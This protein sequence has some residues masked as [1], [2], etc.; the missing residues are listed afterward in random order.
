MDAP[1]QEEVRRVARMLRGE[2]ERSIAQKER[3]GWKSEAEVTLTIKGKW[4]HRTYAKLFG[5]S[6]PL[7]RIVA[8]AREP[9]KIIVM[10][11]AEKLLEAAINL[12]GMIEP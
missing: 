12:E 7:G 4:G 6:G 1:K 2:A 9:G 10:F 11:P 8:D 3:F 5:T